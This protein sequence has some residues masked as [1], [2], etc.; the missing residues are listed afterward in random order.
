MDAAEVFFIP[1][2]KLTV[3]C[4]TVTANKAVCEIMIVPVV[5]CNAQ[6]WGYVEYESCD[7]SHVRRGHRCSRDGHVVEVTLGAGRGVDCRATGGGGPNVTARSTYIGP[8]VLLVH[9]TAG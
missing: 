6:R 8:G 4:R 2:L 7:A 5:F 3:R 9:A 1:V